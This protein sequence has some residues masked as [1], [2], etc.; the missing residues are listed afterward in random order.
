MADTGDWISDLNPS[1]PGANAAAGEGDDEIRLIK[2]V[3]KATFGNIDNKIYNAAGGEASSQD[4]TD[5]FAAVGGISAGFVKGMIMPF[6]GVGIPAGWQLC[7][8]KNGTPDMTGRF[9]IGG[10]PDNGIA[11]DQPG[12]AVPNSDED[13]TGYAGA[14]EHSLDIAAHPALAVENMPLHNHHVFVATTGVTSDA[15]PTWELTAETAPAA[16]SQEGGPTEDGDSGYNMSSEAATPTLGKT[17]PYGNQGTA[18]LEH[19]G[20]TADVAAHKHDISGG[21]YPPFYSLRYIMYTGV[22]A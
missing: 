11:Y 6:H 3:L 16:F 18:E 15:P 8:G 19:S 17:S 9:M 13:Y 14:H 5:M 20:D 21:S 4:Y 1:L 10:D 12:G 22:E 7:D 2:K